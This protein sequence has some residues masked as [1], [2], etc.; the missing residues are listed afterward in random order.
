MGKYVYK[1]L[2]TKKKE[3]LAELCVSEGIV[4][5]EG[6]SRSELLE[7]LMLVDAPKVE[8]AEDTDVTD[9]AKD[10]TQSKVETE[11]KVDNTDAAAERARQMAY[12]RELSRRM[13]NR[14]A[15]N[16]ELELAR[17]RGVGTRISGK[18]AVAIELERRRRA[19]GNGK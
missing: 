10:S 16:Y 6:V 1:D 17:R 4:L 11:I 14:V 18:D 5:G 2:R 7:M 12:E 3:E 9:D 19:Y 13:G 15:S 8:I